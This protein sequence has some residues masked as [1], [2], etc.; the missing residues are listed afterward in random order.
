MIDRAEGFVTKAR[1]EIGTVETGDNHTKYGKFTQHDGQPWCGSFI[2]WVANEVGFKGMPDVV[3]T[4]SG[5]E[6]FKKNKEWTD[7]ENAKPEVGDIVFFSFDGKGIQ[8]VGIVIRDAGD[9]T[10]TTVE[11]NTSPDHKPTGSQDNGGEVC[12]KV[13]AYKKNNKRKLTPFIV[14]FGRP[15]W[16]K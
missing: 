7:A 2:M 6:V 1:D 13:R 4:P 16:S 12:M 9:G 8:H 14:G 10:V 11:G 15:K 5:A 3:Y